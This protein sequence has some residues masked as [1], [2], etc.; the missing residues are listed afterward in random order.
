MSVGSYEPGTQTRTLERELQRLADQVALSV[1]EEFEVLQRRGLNDAKSL[2]EVGCGPGYYLSAIQERSPELKLSGIDHDPQM[3]AHAREQS[4][5]DTDRLL[6]ETPAN[7]AARGETF[8]C[9]LLRYVVQHLPNPIEFLRECFQL[10]RPGGVIAVIDVDAPLWGAALPSSPQFAA[11]YRKLETFQSNQGGDRL[12]GRKLVPLLR[13]LNGSPPQLD[14]FC[15]HSEVGNNA[16]F[17]SQL[18]PDRLYR[19]AAEG[20]IT[21]AELLAAEIEVD[22]FLEASDSFV[23]ML[24]FIGTTKRPN[25]GGSA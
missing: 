15:Y 1:D 11:L 18:S 24:G 19:A 12:I 2:L 21:Q 17:R 22:R 25:S 8:D 4:G 23:M 20:L 7:L 9:V 6:N 3:I 10:V 14:S 13:K 16:R 5:L